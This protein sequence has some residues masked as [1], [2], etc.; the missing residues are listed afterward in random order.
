MKRFISIYLILFSYLCYANQDISGIESDHFYDYIIV[1]GNKIEVLIT[2]KKFYPDEH[3]ITFKD[4]SDES[5]AL[6][7]GKVPIG[8]DNSA[9]AL[10][11]IDSFVVK[12][13]G[14]T[15]R[16]S[17]N[18]YTDCYNPNVR[19]SSILP[20][21]DGHE[22]LIIMSGSDGGGGYT[23]GWLIRK[24]GNHK[25]YIYEDNYHFGE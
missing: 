8:T 9:Y 17:K 16:I 14:N 6:I 10:T 21:E 3:L 2:Q 24:N 19:S 7:D 11:E 18:L 1:S 23:I 13:N 22:V 20:S 15:V 25:R 5:S 12:W 4:S